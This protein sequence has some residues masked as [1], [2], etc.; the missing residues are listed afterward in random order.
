VC[1]SRHHGFKNGQKIKLFVTDGP[2]QLNDGFAEVTNVTQDT[3]ELAGVST[4]GIGAYLPP[5]RLATS[6]PLPHSPD[7]NNGG[8]G[9]NATL[10]ASTAGLLV[11]DGSPAFDGDIVLVKDQAAAEQNGVYLVAVAGDVSGRWRLVRASYFD[12]SSKMAAGSSVQISQ[13]ANADHVFSLDGAV[14]TVGRDPLTFSRIEQ[15]TYAV[16]A[17]LFEM[18]DA[19]HAK[20]AADPVGFLTKYSWFNQQVARAVRYG[21]CDTTLTVSNSVAAMEKIF[22]LRQ[23]AIAEA[24]GLTLRQYEGGCDVGGG[25]A[26]LGNPVALVYGGNAQFGEYLFNFGHSNEVGAVYTDN[27]AAFSRIGGECPAKFVADGR[28]S[29]VGTWG[30]VRFW[31][32]R[33]NFGL[34]DIDNPVWKATLAANAAS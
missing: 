2:R 7:Y 21:N 19:S 10:I 9:T 29:T 26:L 25:G 24:N 20:H 31:P 12:A 34:A 14:K 33:A 17:T 23:L 5:C 32:L 18:M 27:Y 30:A 6:E 22:W 15:N 4:V 8:N 11:I 28:S 3:F 13:G 1:T 16:D